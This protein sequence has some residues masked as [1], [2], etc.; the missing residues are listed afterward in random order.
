MANNLGLEMREGDTFLF[1]GKT[2]PGK[3]I[4]VPR[5]ATV[6]AKGREIAMTL[7]RQQLL[8]P[9][10]P[11]GETPVSTQMYPMTETHWRL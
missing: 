8:G 4:G 5:I 3:E 10:R 6:T 9:N 7:R 1:Q 2:I 11:D